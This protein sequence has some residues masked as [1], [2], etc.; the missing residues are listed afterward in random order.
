MKFIDQACTQLHFFT[1]L[2]IFA[3]L[4]Q[5][6]NILTGFEEILGPS[7]A[8]IC[9]INVSSKGA[10]SLRRYGITFAG[11]IHFIVHFHGTYCRPF[12][13][14]TIAPSEKNK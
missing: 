11:N 1:L 10:A 9:T 5:K 8:S 13:E 6:E 12:Q 4:S 14:I 2:I 3:P 7:V